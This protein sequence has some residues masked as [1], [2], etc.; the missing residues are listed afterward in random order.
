MN[1]RERIASCID[2]T[3]LSPQSRHEEFAAACAFAAAN[4][5]ASVCVCPFFV[6]EAAAALAGTQV[7][8][9]TVIGFPHGTHSTAAKVA[10]AGL[11]MDDGATELDMVVN[12]SKV[13]D[14]DWD[15]VRRD[16]AAVCD[17]V[18]ARGALLKVIFECCFLDDEEKKRLCE[19]C[20][21]TGVDFVKTSTGYGSGG[22]TVHDVE[23]MKSCVGPGVRIKAA[24]GIHTAEELLALLQDGRN[25]RRTAG[26]KTPPPKA[27][28]AAL[29]AAALAAAGC[30]GRRDADEGAWQVLPDDAG[31]RMLAYVEQFVKNS[32]RDAGTVGAAKA[33]RYIAQE[34]R[35]M[36]VKPRADC[37]TE[38]TAQ[39]R[40]TFCNVFAEFPGTSGRTVVVASHYDTKSGIPGF[41][42]ANDGGSSTAILL[43]L[44]E[45]FAES[46]SRPRD[47]IRFAFFDGEEAVGAYRDDD[48]LH[49]SRRMA[50]QFASRRGDG[51]LIAVI[52][53]DMV[54][55]A[56]LALDIPRNVTPWLARA[57]IKASQSRRGLPPVSIAKSAIIDD[58]VPFVLSGFPAIDFIDFEYGSAPGRHDWWHTAEDTPD[59]LSARSLY[60]SASLVLALLDRIDRDDDVPEELKRQPQ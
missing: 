32:P 19:T 35:R 54:G 59:K 47:T 27:F 22:A 6:K 51:P 60:R 44:V 8:V 31:V 10:E 33:S 16:V 20:T 52:V 48:G 12:V 45:H 57:A 9:C 30:A 23:L 18:H 13:K 26:M 5:C 39:G 25:T 38:S 15:W 37:W 4:R 46:R 42:G 40:R 50:M 14:R 34:L 1:L 17:A 28:A 24:G 58:H 55:D 49:G 2:H 11:A 41:V 29:A 43:G 53:L 21:E 36:G 3:V 56:N 7:A